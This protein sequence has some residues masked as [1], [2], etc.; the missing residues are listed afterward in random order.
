MTKVFAVAR[1]ALIFGALAFASGARAD[2][3]EF[4]PSSADPNDTATPNTGAYGSTA[5]VSIGYSEYSYNFTHSY[6]TLDGGTG[7]A[8]YSDNNTSTFVMTFNAAP[9]YSVTLDSFNLATYNGITGTNGT[10]D[11]SVTGGGSPYSLSGAMPSPSTF[12]TYSPGETGTSLTLTIT[13]LYDVGINTIGFTSTPLSVP[14]PSSMVL[15]A[16][17]GAGLSRIARRRRKA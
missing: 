3:I 11:I 1:F 4:T 15:V 14:E 5:A 12:T 8:V 17:G 13:N 10:V 2:I 16:I 9:G 7:D 6:G